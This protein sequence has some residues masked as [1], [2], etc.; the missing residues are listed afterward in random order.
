MYACANVYSNDNGATFDRPQYTATVAHNAS[1]GSVLVRV[2]A[3]DADVSARADD[4][5]YR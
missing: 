5:T 3:T 1:V 4:I 2:H